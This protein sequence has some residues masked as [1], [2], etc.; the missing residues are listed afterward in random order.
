METYTLKVIAHIRTELPE[1]FGVPR[2]SGLIPELK[3]KIVFEPEYRSMD[4]LRG[5]EEFSHLWLIWQFSKAARDTWSP[6][7]R[8]PRLGGNEKMGVFATRSPFRP[9]AIGLS[10]VELEKVELDRELGPVIYVRGVDLMDGTPIF[11]IKPYL[12]YADCRTEAT[13]GWTDALARP[14]LLVEFPAEVLEKIPEEHR[15]AVRAVLEADPRPRYQDD[16]QRIYG[17]TFAK[18]NIKFRVEGETLYVVE[19]EPA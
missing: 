8:P 9:N 17:L 16:P 13:G 5:L 2:Q 10:C 12:P 18:W 14:L 3:G 4:A 11:D 15:D 6:L 1:K 7:V 19:V